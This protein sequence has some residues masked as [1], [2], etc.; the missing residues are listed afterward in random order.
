MFVDR[1]VCIHPSSPPKAG[2]GQRLLNLEQWSSAENGFGQKC[3]CWVTAQHEKPGEMACI[4]RNLKHGWTSGAGGDWS[5]FQSKPQ[6]VTHC[7]E[8][9]RC[10]RGHC[11]GLL[12]DSSGIQGTGI[13]MQ[14][15]LFTR[16]DKN[17]WF[18]CICFFSLLAE[19]HGLYSTAT[20]TS[21]RD[22]P[23]P[24]TF[25]HVAVTHWRLCKQRPDGWRKLS[26]QPLC[27]AGWD[28]AP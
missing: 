5:S 16:M 26:S 28:Q 2:K 3:V 25:Q 8:C 13:L 24:S 21:C 15:C 14:F 19:V 17:T 18:H 10:E 12:T 23:C 27:L 1:D 4:R 20:L 9:W 22:A 6:G 11:L 7:P